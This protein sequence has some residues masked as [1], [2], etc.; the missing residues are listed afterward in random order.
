MI[1]NSFLS[2][3]DMTTDNIGTLRKSIIPYLRN[4]QTISIDI[5]GNENSWAYDYVNYS[6]DNSFINPSNDKHIV[7]DITKEWRAIKL[8][9]AK[10]NNNIKLNKTD[11]SIS[12]H[13][14]EDL[15]D[16]RS[17]ISVLEEVSTKGII[18]VPSYLT[19]LSPM[20]ST[21][22]TGYRHHHW[23][24]HVYDGILYALE[25]DKVPK[26]VKEVY[27]PHKYELCF[28]WNN[29]IPYNVVDTWEEFKKIV[30]YVC[31]I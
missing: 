17:A 3:H 12:S 29:N 22:Y 25:K 14:L 27:N 21:I 20:E 8:I 4:E 19:E 13:T 28:T 15:T 24:L 7:T 18:L 16:F 23:L 6:V 11:I 10:L 31:M 30:G 26:D 5:C 1:T 2:A 9:Q